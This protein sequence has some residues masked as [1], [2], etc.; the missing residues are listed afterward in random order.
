MK[1]RMQ[2]LKGSAKLDVL[3]YSDDVQDINQ[4]MDPIMLGIQVRP[5]DLAQDPD[6]SSIYRVSLHYPPVSLTV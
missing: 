1:A 6:D 5:A 2:V 4:D 3:V